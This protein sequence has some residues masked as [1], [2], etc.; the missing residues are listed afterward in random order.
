VPVPDCA[1][2]SQGQPGTVFPRVMNSSGISWTAPDHP[3]K[4]GGRD[5]AEVALADLPMTRTETVRPHPG[6]YGLSEFFSSLVC[7]LE[8]RYGIEP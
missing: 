4:P 3:R 6:L 2:T 7:E 5:H 1:V 8:P